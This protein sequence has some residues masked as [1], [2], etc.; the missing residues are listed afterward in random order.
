MNPLETCQVLADIDEG[1]VRTVEVAEVLGL[2]EKMVRNLLGPL[3]A[4]GDGSGGRLLRTAWRMVQQQHERS[5]R[6]N[7]NA[8][9]GCNDPANDR[10]QNPPA[11]SSD[12]LPQEQ[13]LP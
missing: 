7:P 12:V 1:G 4:K 3:K 9:S 2:G 5:S 11:C 8:C 10:C 13:P 6:D